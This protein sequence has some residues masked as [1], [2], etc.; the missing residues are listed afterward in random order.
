MFVLW[1]DLRS[2]KEDLELCVSVGDI[3]IYL[4]IEKVKIT[5]QI[6]AV[7]FMHCTSPSILVSINTNHTS[8][9]PSPTVLVSRIT[10][11]SLSSNYKKTMTPLLLSWKAFLKRS[12]V[13]LKV[14]YCEELIN[15][16]KN[17]V[18]MYDKN[19]LGITMR[20]ILSNQIHW[21]ATVCPQRHEPH[22]KHLGITIKYASVPSKL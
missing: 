2:W 17:S 7:L 14:C 4:N 11:F 21:S 15:V 22:M 12:W 16:I 6:N 18:F 20:D 3:L 13:F 9:Y 10:Y 5:Y 8:L 19:D 1:L